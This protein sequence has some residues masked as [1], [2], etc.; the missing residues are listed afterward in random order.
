MRACTHRVTQRLPGHESGPGEV[1]PA[2]DDVATRYPN[3]GGSSYAA[4]AVPY[5]VQMYMVSKA[6][7][8]PGFSGSSKNPIASMS[9]AASSCAIAEPANPNVIAAIMAATVRTRIIRFKGEVLLSA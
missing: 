2:Q 6:N 3:T 1:D 9:P 8:Q 7:Q 4:V 5:S